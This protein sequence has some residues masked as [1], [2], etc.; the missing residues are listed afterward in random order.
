M[1]SCRFLSGLPSHATLLN[2]LPYCC[3][4][5][6]A[7]TD[8]AITPTRVV[9][10]FWTRSDRIG[11]PAYFLYQSCLLATENIVAFDTSA[12]VLRGGGGGVC[13]R[14][15]GRPLGDELLAFAQIPVRCS[16]VSTLLPHTLNAVSGSTET[17]LSGFGSRCRPCSALVSSSS[18]LP[19]SS[20]ASRDD[21]AGS[22]LPRTMNTGGCR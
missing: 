13:M 15:S 2:S 9:L 12:D 10:G 5:A 11:M 17:R 21:R 19:P 14:G 22:P 18:R 16:S 7:R 20:R 6:C 3:S 1:T 8:H 4:A